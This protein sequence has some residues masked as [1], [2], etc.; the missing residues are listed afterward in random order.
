MV[1]G[2]ST[3]DEGKRVQDFLTTEPKNVTNFVTSFMDDL[4]P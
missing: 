4:L 1:Q 2:S 3:Y